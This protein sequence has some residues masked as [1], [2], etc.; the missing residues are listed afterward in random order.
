M[1]AI[2]RQSLTNRPAD[3][4]PTSGNNYIFHKV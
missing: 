2:F 4:G 1:I 3:S